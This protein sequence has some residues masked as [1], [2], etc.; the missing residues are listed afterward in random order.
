MNAA[1]QYRLQQ[2]EQLLTSAGFV[3]LDDGSWVPEA[4]AVTFQSFAGV[5]NSLLVPGPSKTM[6]V[7]R[8]DG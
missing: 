4:E 6:R 8:K 1:E 2:A 5:E 3:E 7:V